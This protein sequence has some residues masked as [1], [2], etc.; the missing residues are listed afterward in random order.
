MLT[1]G[2]AINADSSA[3]SLSELADRISQSANGT[4]EIYT[5]ERDAYDQTGHPSKAGSAWPET[6]FRSA[7]DR[8][9]TFAK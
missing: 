2:E 7:T 6:A 1:Y 4:R 9:V 5:A 3:Y 8:R